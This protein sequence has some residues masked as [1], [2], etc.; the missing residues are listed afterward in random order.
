[1]LRQDRHRA[2]LHGELRGAPCGELPRGPH[3]P[4]VDRGRGVRRLPRRDAREGD[5][6]DAEREQH[7]R[8]HAADRGGPRPVDPGLQDGHADQRDDR[9]EPGPQGSATDACR[10]QH[11]RDVS[12]EDLPAEREHQSCL[13]G[14]GAGCP[15][16]CFREQKMSGAGGG[17]DIFCSPSAALAPAPPPGHARA[18]PAPSRRTRDVVLPPRIRPGEHGDLGP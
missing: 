14:Q 8:G 18:G 17:L 4:T 13:P 7:H 9:R 3:L 5:E 15:D 6:S 12:A 16:A 10:I 2:T 11:V 1:V